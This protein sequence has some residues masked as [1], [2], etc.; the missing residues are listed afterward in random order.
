MIT[1]QRM[2]PIRPP[3]MEP[4]AAPIMGVGRSDG[5]SIYYL[6]SRHHD[7]TRSRQGHLAG[8][9]SAPLTTTQRENLGGHDSGAPDRR[10]ARLPDSRRDRLVESCIRSA[11]LRMFA[12]TT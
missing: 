6:H 9:T 7:R 1:I 10:S 3:K 2:K 5:A 12:A 11:P 4:P 8:G